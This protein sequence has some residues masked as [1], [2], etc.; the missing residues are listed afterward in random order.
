MVSG[1]SENFM[2]EQDCLFLILQS[3][4]P[5][6]QINWGD[7]TVEHDFQNREYL[8]YVGRQTT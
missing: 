2:A 5:Q 3:I 8:E 4:E 6:R 1:R 7:V